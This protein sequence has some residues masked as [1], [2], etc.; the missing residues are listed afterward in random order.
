MNNYPE[1]QAEHA[2]GVYEWSTSDNDTMGVRS[3]QLLINT[4]PYGG[5]ATLRRKADGQ[6]YFHRANGDHREPTRTASE[7]FQKRVVE[8]ARS[9]DTDELRHDT[10]VAA[11][12]EELNNSAGAITS[13]KEDIEEHED[14]IKEIKLDLAGLGEGVA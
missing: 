11:L 12:H 10:K 8:I 9:V 13:L 5:I 4:V 3:A 6:F 1:G 7:V 14:R 2:E